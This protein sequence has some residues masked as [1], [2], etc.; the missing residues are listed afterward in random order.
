MSGIFGSIWPILSSYRPNAARTRQAQKDRAPERFGAFEPT[1]IPPGYAIVRPRTDKE[2]QR[3]YN[4]VRTVAFWLDAAPLLSDLGLPFRAGLDDIISLVP[5]YGDI[6]SGVLQLY[7]VWL[8]FIYGV[9][10][11]ILGRMLLNVI[12]DVII[13]FVPLFGDVLDNLFKSNLRNLSLLEE[14]LLSAPSAQKYHIL[15]MPDGGEFLPKPKTSSA[16]SSWFSGTS[17]DEVRERERMEGRVYKTRRMGK[18]EGVG[19]GVGGASG[20]NAGGTR[21]RRDPVFEPVD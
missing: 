17:V 5:I 15:L 16:W 4:H 9:P 21:K 12:L 1:Y 11:E 18:D 6:L 2:A 13:G 3:L 14:W 20:S 19:A 8:S 10:Y 7:Q